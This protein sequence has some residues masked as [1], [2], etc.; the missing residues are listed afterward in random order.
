MSEPKRKGRRGPAP[1]GVKGTVAAFKGSDEFIAWFGRLLVHARHSAA[2]VIE[3][4]LIDYAKKIGFE[5]PPPP[6]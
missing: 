4:A 6:R 1:R 3:H 2:A 5:E